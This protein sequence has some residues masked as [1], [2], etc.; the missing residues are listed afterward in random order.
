MQSE[1]L[2][3]VARAIPVHMHALRNKEKS[4]SDIQEVKAGSEMEAGLICIKIIVCHN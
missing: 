4:D 2:N 3:K 1:T